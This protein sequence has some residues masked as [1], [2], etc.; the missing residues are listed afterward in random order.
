M[1][2]LYVAYQNLLGEL[3]QIFNRVAQVL[4]FND[5]NLTRLNLVK[6]ALDNQH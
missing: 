5:T 3:F 6:L 1:N 2:Y 4:F